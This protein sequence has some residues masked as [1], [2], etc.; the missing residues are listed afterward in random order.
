M[1]VLNSKD[2]F[3]LES[4]DRETVMAE[5]VRP[6]Y[7]IPEGVKAD[8]L[9][10][11]MKKS[12]NKFAIVLDEYGGMVG[13]VTI[14]DLVERLVGSFTDDETEVKEEEK[15]IEQGED[16]SYTVRGTAPLAEVAEALGVD[17]P[18]DDYETFGGY[19]F[20]ELGSIPEDGTTCEVETEKLSIRVTNVLDHQ[21]D[22]AIVTVTAPAE[23]DEDE[24]E[25]E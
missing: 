7:F 24:D 4:R 13:I 3:R 12:H 2:Y 17:L 8:L 15:L 21:M 11:N 9:F 5:A 22:T 14:N 6:A 16:G 19:V 25:N 20:A 1:G 18:I 23:E 10:R